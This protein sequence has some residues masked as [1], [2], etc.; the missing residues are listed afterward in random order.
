MHTFPP[1][2]RAVGG[3]RNALSRRSTSLMTVFM[4]THTGRVP[5]FQL[6]ISFGHR[7]RPEISLPLL[8]FLHI[9]AESSRGRENRAA[10]APPA[11]PPRLGAP[12]S[13]PEP[14]S[15]W[16]PRGRGTLP[17]GQQ[18]AIAPSLVLLGLLERFLPF[19]SPPSWSSRAPSP[20]G[21]EPPGHGEGNPRKSGK[22]K[23][24]LS[25]RKKI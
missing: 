6:L 25:K 8:S 1:R 10:R 22:K 7:W 12:R 17:T 20:P 3:S 14:P 2:E 13:P 19:F 11:R 23:K 5:S 21:M 4:L 15:P 18:D 9:S 16:A 24:E